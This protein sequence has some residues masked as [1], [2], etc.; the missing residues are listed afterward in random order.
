MTDDNNP[1]IPN[2]AVGT[3]T[4]GG[5]EN[6]GNALIN[7]LKSENSALKVCKIII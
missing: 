7:E 5:H 1:T 2:S 4:N 3:N 6:D